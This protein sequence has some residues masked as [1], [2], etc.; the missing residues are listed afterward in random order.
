VVGK[1]QKEI[2]AELGLSPETQVCTGALDQACGAIG[3]GNIRR[4]IFSENTGA[5]LA[6]C[7]SVEQAT[8]DPADQMPCHYHGL[9]GLYML[10]T[11]TSGGI[12]LRWFRDEF[13]QIEMSVGKT[14]GIDA[15]DLLGK[16]AE[17]VPA[18]SEGLVMLPHLQGAMAPEANPDARGV[19]YG[20]TLRHR[21]SHFIRAIMESVCFIV[22]RNIE[23]VEGMG[24]PVSEIRA[25]GGGA[26]SRIWKQI[27]ADIT[28]RPVLT[29]A[30][31]EAATLGA[32]I[33]AGK[34]VGLY[35]SVEEAVGQM[36]QIKERF[37]PAPGNMAVYDAGFRI[38]VDLYN[39][40]CPLFSKGKEG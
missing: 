11:F 14:S 13:A 33:L 30:N 35:S 4:G 24:V 5:A 8:L 18:G 3:V 9:P 29:T 25:L 37:E 34:A 15:Y 12:V 28:G 26:R 2:A 23:V 36:V 17:K 19:F 32:A 1:L 27:E 39:A 38:Y 6:I 22:R 16:E 40:L 7:A 31:E 20:F 10:H 21:R